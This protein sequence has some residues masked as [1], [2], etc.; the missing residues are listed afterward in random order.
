ML[1][2]LLRKLLRQLNEFIYLISQ[3]IFACLCLNQIELEVFE[4]ASEQ[5]LSILISLNKKEDSQKLLN[6]FQI[7]TKFKI[8][9]ITGPNIVNN[10]IFYQEIII[11]HHK[12][13]S[14]HNST[15]NEIMNRIAK[16]LEA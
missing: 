14:I 6:N 16:I 10:L 7:K 3:M 12:I 2:Q 15:N 11:L 1:H 8:D 4:F 13:V 5:D 9:S